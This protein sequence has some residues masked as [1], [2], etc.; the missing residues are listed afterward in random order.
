LIPIN[1]TKALQLRL[2]SERLRR[3][4]GRLGR[5]LTHANELAQINRVM[6]A[7]L[8][9]HLREYA[10]LVACH[11]DAWIIHTESAA[12]ATRLRYVLPTLRQQL[13]DHL[14]CEVPKLRLRIRPKNA[15]PD[16]SASIRRMTVSDQ[17][18]E[19]LE[20][21]AND[22]NDTRLSSAMKRLAQ[23]ARQRVA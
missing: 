20:G 5:L 12:W 9:S 8:P 19:V 16:R 17:A 10:N 6:H 13:A 3:S 11:P 14:A 15:R 7:F 23:H 22:V 18:A 2:I 21:A 1:T 4:H